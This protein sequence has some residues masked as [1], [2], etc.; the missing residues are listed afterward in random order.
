MQIKKRKLRLK[1]L[2]R[3]PLAG[4]LR[5]KQG[6]SVLNVPLKRSYMR[7]PEDSNATLNKEV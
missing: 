5:A 1:T 3:N 7:R 6:T 4:K 2:R